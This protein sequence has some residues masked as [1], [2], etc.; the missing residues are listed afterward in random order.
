MVYANGTVEAWGQIIYYT[1]WEAASL[2]SQAVGD[3]S[4]EQQCP[5][6]FQ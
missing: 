2:G 6:A 3:R 5:Q 1:F 4:D